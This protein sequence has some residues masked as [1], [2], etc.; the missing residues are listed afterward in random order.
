MSW[1][2]SPRAE[3]L[4]VVFNEC[5]IGLYMLLRYS[6]NL[7]GISASSLRLAEQL[8][9]RKRTDRNALMSRCKGPCNFYNSGA[10]GVINPSKAI[11]PSPK[12]APA[13]LAVVRVMERRAKLL[14]LD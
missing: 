4:A 12:S 14:G 1:I 5:H 6:K 13:V 2:R 9:T 8:S 10:R 11:H 3:A 7:T